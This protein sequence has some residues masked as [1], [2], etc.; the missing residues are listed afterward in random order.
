MVSHAQFMQNQANQIVSTSAGH[1]ILSSSMNHLES[2]SPG[3]MSHGVTSTHAI[4][5]QAMSL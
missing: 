1:I 3:A 4:A 2:V 5:I